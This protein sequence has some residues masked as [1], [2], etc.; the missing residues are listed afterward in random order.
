MGRGCTKG[1]QRSQ[2]SCAI[3][4][5]YSQEQDDAAKPFLGN[6]TVP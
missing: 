3:Q 2:G 5:G 6:V 1:M 4:V